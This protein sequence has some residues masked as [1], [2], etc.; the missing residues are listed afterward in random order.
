MTT[1]LGV[2]GYPKGWVGVW[3]NEAGFMH[4]DV[5]TALVELIASV[6]NT[7]WVAVD[8]PIG[9]PESGSRM[10]DLLARKLLGERRSSVFPTPPR[11]S[12]G[13]ETYEEA[14]EIARA[15]NGKGISRQAF[16]LRTKI[17]EAEDVAQADPRLFEVHPEVSFVALC[18]GLTGHQQLSAYKKT[19]NGL[20][21]RLAALA[22]VGITI[23]PD[24]GLAGL[25]GADDVA[26]AAL[27]AWS[28]RRRAEGIH[29]TL[30]AEPEIINNRPCAIFY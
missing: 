11:A 30:P 13:A 14:S 15:L 26:D 17:L 23:P 21:Q 25:A 28:A 7:Q 4:A 22:R 9:C 1:V 27:A 8:I 24:L 18:R 29:D 6:P 19:W 5:N 10:A 2:D 16:E 3:L 12:L 20:A